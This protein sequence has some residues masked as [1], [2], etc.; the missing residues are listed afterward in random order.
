M[1]NITG[2]VVICLFILYFGIFL[3][4]ILKL[5]ELL[6]KEEVYKKEGERKLE[7]VRLIKTGDGHMMNKL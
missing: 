6:K 1:E 2:I 4:L 5:K 3:Y 7:W